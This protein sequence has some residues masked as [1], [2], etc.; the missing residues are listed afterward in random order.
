MRMKRLI[1]LLSYVALVATASFGWNAKS[2][3]GMWFYAMSPNGQWIAFSD[4]GSAGILHTA[5]SVYYLYETDYLSTEYSL[6][7]GNVGNDLGMFVGSTDEYT[8]PTG[9][10][11]H[12]HRCR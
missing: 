12:G 10:T 11:A 2:Y 9:R 6:G 7:Q 3:P 1:L 5:D 4:D 8:P